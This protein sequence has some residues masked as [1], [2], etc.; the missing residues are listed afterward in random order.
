[1]DLNAA[2]LS[3][4]NLLRQPNLYKILYYKKLHYCA[5]ISITCGD[6]LHPFGEVVRSDKYVFVLSTGVWLDLS[7]KIQAPLLE[8]SF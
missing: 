3:V 6:G 5:F 4:T 2:A 8:R 1:M 7:N